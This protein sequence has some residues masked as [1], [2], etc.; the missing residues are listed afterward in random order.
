METF[1][2]YSA[3][4]YAMLLAIG[5][6]LALAIVV[7]RRRPVD[8]W[9]TGPVERAVALGYLAVWVA[10]FV[11]LRLSRYYDPLSTYPLQMCHWCAVVAAVSLI[12][13]QR[14]LRAIAYF[15]GLALCTQ[16]IITPGL[17]EGPALYR[18]WFF[19]LS[20]GL[21]L[22][23]PLYDVAA[24]G[25]RPHWRDY[26]IG[27]AAALAYV[28]IVLPVD[29]LTGWNYGFVGPGKPETPSIV[30]LLGPWPLRLVWIVLLAAAAML[31]VFLP[32]LGARAALRWSVTSAAAHRS[33]SPS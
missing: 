17:T 32:W 14:A 25:Y 21:V 22:G 13:P 27:C 20:H 9:A 16:A 7:R 33:T 8:A 19:W 31:V 24:R 26:A 28:A 2:P 12:R 6:A 1:R 15:C 30:D 18:F 10:S 23:V 4:H 11:W 29:L 3:W 5:A